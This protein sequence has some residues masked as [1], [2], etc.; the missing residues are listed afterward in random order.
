MATDK[1]IPLRAAR[2]RGSSGAADGDGRT[3][4]D[5]AAGK[6]SQN[7]DDCLRA[8]G[9]NPG[10]LFQRGGLLVHPVL[11]P[12]AAAD[13][14]ET[15]SHRI[16]LAP[17]AYVVEL[18]TKAARIT[19]FDARSGQRVECNCP[20][21][22][23]ETLLGRGQWP[24][25]VLV[26]VINAPTLRPDGSVL[27][28][29]GYDEATGLLFEPGDAK[30]PAISAHPSREDALRALDFL[31][32]LFASFPLVTGSK[33]GADLSVALSAVLTAFV[34]PAIPTA[35]LHAFT[36][37]V[38]GSG[39]SLLVDVV[40]MIATGRLAAVIAQGQLQEESEKRLA[41]ALLAGECNRL[42]R[43]LRVGADGRPALPGAHAIDAEGSVAWRQHERRGTGQCRDICDRQ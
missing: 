35:P 36:A 1:P 19:K 21:F 2:R 9:E 38:S 18:I 40:A 3:T 13:G 23:A 16:T 25:R 8:L 37:P 24:L 22:I 29:P 5:L 6:L 14:R 30:F 15:L 41:A 42:D 26:R 27:D 43:Q 32:S 31:K 28:R 11:S 17:L 34:R 7:I 39:K 33:H 4:I 10:D 12:V 20:R